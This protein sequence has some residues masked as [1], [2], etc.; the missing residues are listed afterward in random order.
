[1]TLVDILVI[2]GVLYM[3][4]KNSQSDST[5][6]SKGIV[7]TIKGIFVKEKQEND[8][9]EKARL[10]QELE[11]KIQDENTKAVLNQL[12]PLLNKKVK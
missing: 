8:L 7:S 2:G 1:M 11:S 4:Y 5:S 10:W 6:N 12:W 9:L 3:M